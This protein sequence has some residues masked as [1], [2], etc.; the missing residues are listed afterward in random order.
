VSTAAGTSATTATDKF[1]YVTSVS[2][3]LP[4]ISKCVV[5]RLK[6]KRLKAARKRARKSNCRIGLVKLRNGVSKKTGKVVKQK[7]KAGK[8]KAA[9]SKIAVTL[10]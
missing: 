9:G 2:T 8:V 1:T 4:K 5:P 3:G 10:G 6:G 7:P